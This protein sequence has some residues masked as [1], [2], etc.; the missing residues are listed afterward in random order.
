MSHAAPRTPPDPPS[1][2]AGAGIT[3][4]ALARRL[5]VSPTTL[6]S[7]DRRYG[8]GPA[9]RPGGRH[10]RWAPHDVAVLEEMCRLTATGLPPAEAARLALRAPALPRPRRDGASPTGEPARP[11][12]PAPGLPRREPSDEEARL[13]CR[14]LV[15]A[16]VRL[17]AAAVQSGLTAAVRRYGL[18]GAW[19]EVMVPALRAAG[20]RWESSGDR[21]VEVEHLLSWH[22]SSVLRAEALAAAPPDAAGH[23][24]VLACVPDEQHT[25]PLEALN[26]AAVQASVATRMLGGAVPVEALVPAVRRTGPRVL[27]LWSQSRSTSS[28]PLAQHLAAARWGVRGART[29]PL[30]VAAGPGWPPEVAGTA[31]PRTLPEALG[32]LL[33][34]CGGSSRSLPEDPRG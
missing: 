11:A 24:A 8:L 1:G 25:L 28:V 32:L 10:R 15:R 19:Q 34:A 9:V 5:G 13:A 17:D 21:Y 23:T 31:R 18:I 26:A 3:T 4:G 20:R 33:D 27:V 14:G 29:R 7:W 30:V 6:R 2:E 22:V 16:A 12:P